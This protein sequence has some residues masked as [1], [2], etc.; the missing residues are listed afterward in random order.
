MGSLYPTYHVLFAGTIFLSAFLLFQVQPIMGRYILPW[1]GGGPAVW[2]ICLLFFQ[3]C[4]LA[5]YAYAHWLG[6]LNNLRLQAGIHAALLLGSLAFLPLHPNPA[7]WKAASTADPSA[8][9][10]LLLTVTVGAP[11]LLLASTAPLIQRWFTIS[12]PAKSPWRL[13]ALS[14]FGSFLALLSYPV[15][16]EP[17]FRL[18]T[19]G[20]V[21]SGL[22]VGFALLC[23]VTAFK[24]RGRAAAPV[25]EEPAARPAIGTIVFWFLLAACGSILLVA[26][27]N[28]LSQDVAVSPFLWVVALAIY[29]LTFM[30]AFESDRFYRRTLFAIAAGVFAPIASALPTISTGLSLRWQLIVYLVGLFVTCMICQGELARSRP[31]PRYLTLF[32]LTIA[33]GGAAGG[34]FVAI[35]A[36]RIFTEFSEYPVGLAAACLLG[37]LGWVR[38]GAIKQWTSRNFAVR[39]PLMALLIGGF[40]AI[41]ASMTN[42]KQAPV[43]SIRNFYGVLHIFERDDGHGRFRELQHGRTRHGIEYLEAAR[44]DLA[45]SYYGPHSGI[46]MALEAVDKPARRIAVVGLG[47]GTLAAWGR[48][49]DRFRFYEINPDVERIARTWFSY[50]GDSK[51]RTEVVLGDARVQL[52]RE[53]DAGQSQN[54]DLIAV[55]AFSGD[56]IPMHLLTAECADIYRRR[57]APGGVLALH[58]SNRTVN[59]DPVAR[60]MAGYLGWKAVEIISADDAATG[61]SSSRWVLLSADSDFFDRSGL[62]REASVWTPRPPILWTD[63]F[64]SLWPVLTF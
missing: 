56:S 39:L 32:Y 55:D 2:T 23:G 18:S 16:F 20:S 51:A 21:W 45:T 60:G 63:D 1:F 6:S 58:I 29:L 7:L 26:T 22:Y 8:R 53:L 64:A 41:A 5:G 36:P 28:Q 37:F 11:Y 13:Y 42:G 62:S 59:L 4:L 14:N 17:S 40:A 50:L 10:L 31:S 61:E 3:S 15:F 34:L 19:Q 24:T 38:T 12:L 49:G 30:L 48:P 27:T 25:Q 47:A 9:I 54:F 35:V 52:T 33:A 57:L 46:A 44:K 43:A